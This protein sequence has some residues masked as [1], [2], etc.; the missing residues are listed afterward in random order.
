MQVIC[1]DKL[2]KNLRLSVYVRLLQQVSM[3]ASC[4]RCLC[5]PPAAGICIGLTG[6]IAVGD[7]AEAHPVDEDVEHHGAHGHQS[8]GSSLATHGKVLRAR[9]IGLRLPSDGALLDDCEGPDQHERA[10]QRAYQGHGEQGT[11]PELPVGGNQH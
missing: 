10:Q 9:A 3:Y 2:S 8:S 1:Q 5:T 11:A 4:S 7:G 6:S